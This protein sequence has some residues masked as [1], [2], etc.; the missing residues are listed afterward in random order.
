MWITLK[1]C[2]KKENMFHF[3][4]FPFFLFQNILEASPVLCNPLILLSQA[5]G[6]RW[7]RGMCYVGKQ[8]QTLI[9]LATPVGRSHLGNWQYRLRAWGILHIHDFKI[10]KSIKS[11]ASL[12]QTE[13]ELQ[14][15]NKFNTHLDFL[16]VKANAS[17]EVRTALTWTLWSWNLGDYKAGWHLPPSHGE[18]NWLMWK[19]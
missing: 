2:R 14:P 12:W 10:Y 19:R 18:R 15:Q 1:D 11:W 8:Q 5:V 7:H 17:S 3:L 13:R 9:S 4:S 6:S 16:D